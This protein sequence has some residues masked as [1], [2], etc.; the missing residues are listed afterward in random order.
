[1]IRHGRCG[2]STSRVINRIRRKKCV[3]DLLSYE[4]KL[5]LN[6][7]E[8]DVYLKTKSKDVG[9]GDEMRLRGA[10][11]RRSAKASNDRL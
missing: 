9:E 7:D 6:I 10:D 2:T 5:G 11:G 8:L 3:R 4:T 1:M